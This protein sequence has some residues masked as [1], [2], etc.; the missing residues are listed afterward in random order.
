MNDCWNLPQAFTELPRQSLA[1]SL[2]LPAHAS[3]QVLES[4]I[5]ASRLPLRVPLPIGHAS[6]R[7]GPF[8]PGK[9]AN[10]PLEVGIAGRQS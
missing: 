8:H 9:R 10:W 1:E 2:L 4:W 7:K 3:N 5:R 6:L